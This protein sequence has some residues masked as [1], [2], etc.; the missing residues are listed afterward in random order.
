MTITSALRGIMDSLYVN[1]VS[2][3]LLSPGHIKI[4]HKDTQV[5]HLVATWNLTT[6]HY[7]SAK[8]IV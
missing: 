1:I 5:M 8:L 6:F 4:R 3:Y 7:K 2:G